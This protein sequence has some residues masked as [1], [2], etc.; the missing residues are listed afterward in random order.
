MKVKP[1]F[2]MPQTLDLLFNFSTIAS[3]LNRGKDSNFQ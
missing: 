3:R 2:E 1:S